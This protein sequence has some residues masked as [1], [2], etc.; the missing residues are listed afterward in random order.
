[1]SRQGSK[2]KALRE[3]NN[4]K[5]F[6]VLFSEVKSI[7]ILIILIQPHAKFIPEMQ[8]NLPLNT[9]QSKLPNHKLLVKIIISFSITFQNISV[10]G[11]NVELTPLR[12]SILLQPILLVFTNIW[13]ASTS[14]HTCHCHSCIHGFDFLIFLLDNPSL[15]DLFALCFTCAPLISLAEEPRIKIMSETVFTIPCMHIM[16][17]Q[18]ISN[19]YQF[20]V[21][22]SLLVLPK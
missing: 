3:E 18:Q 8:K 2:A 13:S 22:I 11:V 9:V 20:T 6:E 15:S 12:L 19:T 21:F 4:K 10:S 7:Q 16:K 5:L 1:M 14:S 17:A